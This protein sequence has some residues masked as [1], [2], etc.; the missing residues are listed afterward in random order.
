MLWVELH[1]LAKAGGDYVFAFLS[2]KSWFVILFFVDADLYKYFAID[3]CIDGFSLVTNIFTLEKIETV[4][5][6]FRYSFAEK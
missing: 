2:C 4:L 6:F 5:T 3:F 1:A